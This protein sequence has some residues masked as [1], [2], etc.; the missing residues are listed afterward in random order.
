MS[1]LTS[2]AP[3]EPKFMP[4]I[5]TASRRQPGDASRWRHRAT[6]GSA[7]VGGMHGP[8]RPQGQLGASHVGDRW[9]L[10]KRAA[11][12]VNPITRLTVDTSL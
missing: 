5:G 11:L 7:A 8:L 12:V 9:F 1:S 2:F 3:H 4:R 10:F 6:S